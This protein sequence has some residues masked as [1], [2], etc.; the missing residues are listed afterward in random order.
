MEK[1]NPWETRSISNSLDIKPD[2]PMRTPSLLRLISDL[3]LDKPT[4]V[5]KKV[6]NMVMAD[7][8]LSGGVI[9]S[10]YPENSDAV[11]G[12]TPSSTEGP[13]SNALLK[14]TPDEETITAIIDLYSAN[15]NEPQ[16]PIL[17]LPPP[18]MEGTKLAESKK[19]SCQGP[20]TLNEPEKEFQTSSLTP[21]F[22]EPE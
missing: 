5:P 13:P 17:N 9:S 8:D 6:E 20:I 12:T 10:L 15:E 16:I 2:L 1:A 19:E 11:K 7:H 14:T 21:S 4:C 18:V 22:H 3:S